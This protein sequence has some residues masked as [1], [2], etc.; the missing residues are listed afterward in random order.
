M[1]LNIRLTPRLEAMIRKKIAAGTY[2]SAGEVVSEAL[3]LLEL[4]E[5]LRPDIRE[6]L[7]SGSSTFF[8]ATKLKRKARKS[9]KARSGR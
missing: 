8:E 2:S 7:E 3:R 5:Q 4:E 1:P 9:L 6:G